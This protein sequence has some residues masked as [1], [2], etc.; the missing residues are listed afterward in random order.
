MQ[1]WEYKQISREMDFTGIDSMMLGPGYG[2]SY[3]WEDID[4]EESERFL[5]E[6]RRLRKLGQEGWELTSV[7]YSQVQRKH[8]YTYYLKR[9]IE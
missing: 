6:M 2:P 9:P 4:V 3:V 1:K 8:I 7:L 5:P